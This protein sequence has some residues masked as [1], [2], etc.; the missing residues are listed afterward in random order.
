MKEQKID[1]VVNQ[2]GLYKNLTKLVHTSCYGH[3]KIFTVAHN[4]LLAPVTS[5]TIVRYSLFKKF[6]LAWLLPLLRTSVVK[7]VMN[8]MYYFLMHTRKNLHFSYPISL[9][10]RYVLSIILVPLY[11]KMMR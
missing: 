5:F 11:A 10:T 9:K 4:S 3:A 2:D 8:A 1:V 7:G 6:H